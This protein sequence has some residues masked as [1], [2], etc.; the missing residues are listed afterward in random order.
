MKRIGIIHSVKVVCS[1]FDLLLENN[2]EDVVAYNL[3]DDW[4]SKKLQEEG[5]ITPEIRGRLVKDLRHQEEL[6]ADAVLCTCSSLSKIVPEVKADFAIPILSIDENM[7]DKI[8]DKSGK[9]LIVATSFSAIAS[10]QESITR[11]T[12]E[13]GTDISISCIFLEGA[14]KIMHRSS[15]MK[16]HD[17]MIIEAMRHVDDSYDF[18][19]FAQASLA[20]LRDRVETITGKQVFTSP[21]YCIEELKEVL[22]Y[23]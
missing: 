13:K 14:G 5:E 16:A 20:H 9:A 21:D 15:D 17:D 4:L 2:M 12:K 18:I 10:V 19:I 22:Y 1:F 7:F 23:E 6:G 3:L 11:Q 8:S